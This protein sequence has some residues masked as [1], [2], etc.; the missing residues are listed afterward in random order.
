MNTL[1]RIPKEVRDFL[2]ASSVAWHAVMGKRHVKVFVKDRLAV[3]LPIAGKPRDQ[4]LSRKNV[5]AT[6]KRAVRAQ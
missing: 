4:G 1:Q 2:E 3:V 6:V 5:L